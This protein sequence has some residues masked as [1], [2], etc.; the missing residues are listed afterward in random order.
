MGIALKHLREAKR[1]EQMAE[2]QFQLMMKKKEEML[3]DLKDHS[4]ISEILNNVES[5]L[6]GLMSKYKIAKEA[7]IMMENSFI[8]NYGKEPLKEKKKEE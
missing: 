2:T 1:K 4:N 5:I 7:H 6:D 8:I 3:K